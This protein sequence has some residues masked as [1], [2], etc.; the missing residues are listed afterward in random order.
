[1]S[2]RLKSA[3]AVVEEQAEE[4]AFHAMPMRH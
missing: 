4:I 1:M 3:Y 2:P